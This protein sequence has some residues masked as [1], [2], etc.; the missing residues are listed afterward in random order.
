MKQDSEIKPGK[1]TFN[2]ED[3][4][5]KPIPD[6]YGPPEWYDRDDTWTTTIPRH[7]DSRNIFRKLKES[8]RQRRI[9]QEKLEQDYD[10]PIECVYGPIPPV[11]QNVVP[12]NV[13]EEKSEFLSKIFEKKRKK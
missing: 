7:A 11:E 12:K 13:K 8:N 5:D 2:P 6:V 1:S 3:I 10:A 4:V 9:L